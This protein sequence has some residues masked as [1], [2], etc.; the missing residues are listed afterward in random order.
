MN[1]PDNVVQDHE[2]AIEKAQ[3]IPSTSKSVLSQQVEESEFSTPT[4]FSFH[5][6]TNRQKRVFSSQPLS[7]TENILCDLTISLSFESQCFDIF[8][9]L[10]IRE[11]HYQ[12]SFLFTIKYLSQVLLIYFSPLRF[13]QLRTVPLNY[14]WK[15]LIQKII[16]YQIGMYSYLFWLS[17]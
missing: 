3:K 8:S 4:A 1:G 6:I 11:Y 14:F 15:Q 5:V 7:F 9:M 10:L 13:T 16:V 12:L 17:C 2:F